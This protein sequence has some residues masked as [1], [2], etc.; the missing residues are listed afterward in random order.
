[1]LPQSIRPNR[2]LG[3][4]FLLNTD[5]VSRRIRAARITRGDVVL[6]VGAGTGIVTASIA[7]KAQRVVAVEVDPQFSECLREVQSRFANVELVWG[8]AVAAMTKLPA[9][10][11]VVASLPYNVSLPVTFAVLDHGFDVAVLLLQERQARRIAATPGSA[12]YSRVSVSVQRRVV[13]EVLEVVPPS[14]FLPAPE[15]AGAVIRLVPRAV[16]VEIASEPGFKNLLDALFVHRRHRLSDA[17]KLIDSARAAELVACAP[18]AA[19]NLPVEQ[20][21]VDDFAH[22]ER[23]LEAANISI[24]PTSDKRKR[25]ASKAPSPPASRRARH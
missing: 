21:A 15:V 11:K 8:D 9:F 25:T 23:G 20:V 1:M 19:R 10:S 6:E 17:L 22:L 2:K 5:V 3:Q 7:A 14:D 13:V 18:R 16:R 12:G 4:N 24:G